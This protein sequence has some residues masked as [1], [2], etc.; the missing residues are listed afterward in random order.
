M[1][2]PRGIIPDEAAFGYNAALISETLRDENG[3]FLPVFVLSLDGQDW[4]QP[5]VQYLQVGTFKIFGKSLFNLKFISVFIASVS[6]LIILLLGSQMLGKK[7]GILAFFIFLTT[8]VIL[9][10][11]HLALDNIAPVPFI[12]LWLFGIYKYQEKKSV[13][14][15]ILSGISLGIG[16]YAHKSMRSAAPVW[17]ILTLIYLVMQ[18]KDWRLFTRKKYKPVILFLISILPFYLISPVLEYKY[19]GAVY[20]TQSISL[21]SVY[22]FIYY[23]ISSFDLSFLFIKGDSILHHS[24]GTHG[25]FLLAALPIFIYGLYKSLQQKNVFLIFLITCLF[26]GPLFFGFVGSVHRASRLIFMVPLFS[27][28]SAYG[29]LNLFEIKSR[30]FKNALIIF[31]LLFAFNF[32][33]FISY[34]W[35]R[36]AGDTSHIFYSVENMEVYE[37]L[38][39]ISREENLNPFISKSLMDLQGNAGAVEDF[40]RSIY[41]TKPQTLS[42]NAEL[43]DNSIFLTSDKNY[44]WGRKLETGIEGYFLFLR[45]N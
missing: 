3:R 20:G 13:K 26:T 22:D 30:I 31:C 33:D 9:I 19:A 1:D 35:F 24:T 32:F 41:F 23:Y 16:F 36:Y 37:K 6:A 38:S 11:S 45:S 5:V 18:N 15:L 12:L 2:V 25:M 40:S 17:T 34:Y 29:L 43:P 39:E 4:R 10:H 28:I 42:D 27:F 21:A 8:P 44:P 14:F 7:F